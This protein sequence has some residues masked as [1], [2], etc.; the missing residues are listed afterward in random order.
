MSEGVSIAIAGLTIVFMA[1]V[2]ISLFIGSLPRLLEFV[3]RIWPEVEEQHSRE[4]SGEVYPAS[5]VP[6]DGA[7]LAAI[8]FVLHTELQRQLAAEQASKG[9]G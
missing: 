8:G 3:A 9:K 7:S 6:E 4:A 5:L 1:L 2:L